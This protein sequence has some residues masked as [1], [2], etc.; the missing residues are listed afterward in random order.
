MECRQN[1]TTQTFVGLASESSVKEIVDP[2]CK[3]LTIFAFMHHS[4][5]PLARVVRPSFVVLLGLWAG[6]ALGQVAT[7]IQLSS[8][9]K[10][11]GLNGIQKNFYFATKAV[12][13]ENDYQSAGYFGQKLRPYLAGNQEAVKSLNRYRRQKW[14]FLA[15]R[16]T[17][18]GSVAAYGAQTFTGG[19]EKQY[20]EGGQRVTLGLAAASLLSNIFIT[21]HT[22][23]H[24]QRAVEAHNAGL[25]SAHDTGML[26]RLMPTGVGVAVA[27]TGQPQLAFSWQLR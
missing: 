7:P 11:R 13:T 14:L 22:N 8:E 20:F 15:E 23:E 4:A 17:F 1:V 16:L 26:R 6:S 21:R 27:R 19:D 5:L 25:S 18:V 12:P 9:D 10:E 3:Q 2:P 24:F